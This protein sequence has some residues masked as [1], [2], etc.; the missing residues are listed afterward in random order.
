MTDKIVVLST[1]ANE[2]EGEKLARLLVE[3]KLA[4]CVNVIPRMRSFYW[5]K[6]AIETSEE[7]LLLVKSS[8][9][10]FERVKSVLASAHSY[11]VPEVVA[12]P[13]VDGSENYMS[14]LEA[15]LKG[16]PRLEQ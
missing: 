6:G 5:W 7:C 16:G 10:L 9:D 15:N 2:Q 12:L 14:W 13:I 3:E 11:E 1:C 4:A 8:R